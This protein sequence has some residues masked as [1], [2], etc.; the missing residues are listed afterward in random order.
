[1]YNNSYKCKCLLFGDNYVY[2]H[3]EPY[4]YISK[5]RRPPRRC[6]SC[7]PPPPVDRREPSRGGD[8]FSAPTHKHSKNKVIFVP[9]NKHWPYN[10]YIFQSTQLGTELC[11][12]LRLWDIPAPKHRPL[13]SFP[14]GAPLPLPHTIWPQTPGQILRWFTASVVRGGGGWPTA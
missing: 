2:A 13:F 11:P 4:T 9:E 10:I 5:A 12:F 7:R 14:A 8:P 1:M 3:W 6:R